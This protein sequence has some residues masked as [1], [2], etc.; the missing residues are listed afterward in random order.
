MAEDIG[1]LRDGESFDGSG[2]HQDDG[3]SADTTIAR[4][5]DLGIVVDEAV[6]R[7]AIQ[8]KALTCDVEGFVR[9]RDGLPLN[10]ELSAVQVAMLIG[11]RRLVFVLGEVLE[12]NLREA[13]GFEAF[14]DLGEGIGDAGHIRLIAN[15]KTRQ[16]PNVVLSV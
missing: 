7:G 6:D 4:G 11:V 3:I 10:R 2:C 9:S 16:K 12:M 15:R 8:P 1:H 13:A 5:S 14:T